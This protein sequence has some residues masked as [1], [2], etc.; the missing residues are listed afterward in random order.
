[1]PL[2]VCAGRAHV[3]VVLTSALISSTQ[4]NNPSHNTHDSGLHERHGL[5]QQSCIESIAEIN[6]SVVQHEPAQQ[7][8]AQRVQQ[9]SVPSCCCGL[10]HPPP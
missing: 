7:A 3:C 2:R 4:I 9:S 8:P 6:D 5:Q 1:M 10:A